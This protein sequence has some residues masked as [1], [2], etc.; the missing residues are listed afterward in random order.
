T[1]GDKF[2]TAS[3]YQADANKSARNIIELENTV[4]RQNNKIGS[5]STDLS[6]AKDE[7]EQT[8]QQLQNFEDITDGDTQAIVSSINTILDSIE[9]LEELIEGVEGLITPEDVQQITTN[10]NDIAMLVT[11]VQTNTN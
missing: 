3:E 7:L 9:S 8:K 2:K 5:L 4:S 1:I 6:N 11:D 10:K